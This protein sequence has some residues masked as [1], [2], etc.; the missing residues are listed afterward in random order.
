LKNEISDEINKWVKIKNFNPITRAIL[1]IFSFLFVSIFVTTHV[2]NDYKMV[3]KIMELEAENKRRMGYIGIL[4]KATMM[5]YKEIS[6]LKQSC[7]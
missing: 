7:N 1:L 2:H 6:Q 5:Q 3:R 4:E